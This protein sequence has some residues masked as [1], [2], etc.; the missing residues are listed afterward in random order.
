LVVCEGRA[1]FTSFFAH[2]RLIGSVAFARR[3]PAV[4]MTAATD[5]TAIAFIIVVIF[6]CKE[7]DGKKK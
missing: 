6:S 4:V 5:T 1:S 7:E 3:A 2:R